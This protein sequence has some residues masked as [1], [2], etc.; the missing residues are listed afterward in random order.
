MT[1]NAVC[2]KEYD[3]EVN[4]VRVNYRYKDTDKLTI[5]DKKHTLSFLSLPDG[6]CGA[7]AF[8]LMMKS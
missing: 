1:T 5:T 8:L 6:F 2:E 4:M 3:E 7:H